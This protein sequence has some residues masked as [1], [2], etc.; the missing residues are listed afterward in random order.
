VV[1]GKIEEGERATGGRSRL[2]RRA[3]GGGKDVRSTRNGDANMLKPE[4]SLA[5]VPV[6]QMKLVVGEVSPAD[7]VHNI[8]RIATCLISQFTSKFVW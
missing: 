6:S 3:E 2:N 7:T 8:Y 5:G 1:T 4:V